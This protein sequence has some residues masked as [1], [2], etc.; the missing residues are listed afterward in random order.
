MN[1]VQQYHHTGKRLSKYKGNIHFKGCVFFK[2]TKETKQFKKKGK[3]AHVS[4][5][6]LATVPLLT[7]ARLRSRQANES[8]L[9]G[10]SVS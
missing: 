10:N 4:S 9:T 6:C 8:T 2:P 7:S 1:T 5:L 3:R